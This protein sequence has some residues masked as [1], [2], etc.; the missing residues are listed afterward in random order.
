[1]S[2]PYSAS[3][4]LTLHPS[5]YTG[6]NSYLTVSNGTRAYTSS[7]DTSQYAT[8]TLSTNGQ[9]GYVY[10]T[11]TVPTIPSGA[12]ISNVTCSARLRA[13]NNNRVTNCSIQLYNETTAQGTA[14]RIGTLSSTS[15]V[16]NIT[17]ANAG[18]WTTSNI[19]NIRLRIT[20]T[21]SSSSSTSIRLYGADLN[22]TYTISGTEYEVSIT[23]NSSTVTSLPSSTEYVLQGEN[24]IIT[25]FNVSNT[26]SIS[27]TDNNVDVTSSLVYS[28]S[29]TK[30]EQFVPSTLYSSSTTVENPNNACTDTSS[31]TYARLPIGQQEQNNMIYSFDV[32]QIPSNATINSVSCVVKVSTST[33][34]NITTKDVQLY[35]GTSPK[36]SIS[37]IPTTTGGTV[38]LSPGTWTRQELE[39]IR[40]RFDGY[41]NGTYSNYNIDFYGADLTINYTANEVTYTYTISNIS[42]DHTII[43]SDAEGTQKV[44]LKVNGSWVQASKVYKKVSGS[45]VEQSDLSN[46]FN[47]NTIY[48]KK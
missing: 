41:Y 17:N 42:A 39:N 36:G 32:S 11:F 13:S 25:F 9:T 23:N 40:I 45:W 7:S 29:L 19:S 44:Y 31:T 35:S 6:N 34:S 38:T 3:E 14:N 30:N 46:V 16:Y 1:M 26:N 33:S 43:I 8:L 47:S 48:I 20:G 37:T 18:D 27:I 12:T 28:A 22:I 24:Q 10:F 21:R 5:G 15:T 4:T 2:R